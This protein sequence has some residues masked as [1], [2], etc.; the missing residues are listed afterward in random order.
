MIKKVL[1][2]LILTVLLTTVSASAEQTQLVDNKVI[3][4]A[5][6]EPPIGG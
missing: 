5:P 1:A 6:K 3:Q 4:Y 2:A